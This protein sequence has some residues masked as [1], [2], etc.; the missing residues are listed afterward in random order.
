MS[1]CVWK[2][3]VLVVAVIG[4]LSWIP[5]TQAEN[6]PQWRGARADGVSI[7]KDIA[8]RWNKQ[9]SIRWRTPLPGQGGATPIVWYEKIFLTSAEGDDLVAMCLA[10]D[11]GKTLW[12]KKIA[13]GNQD[14]RAGE[15]NSASPSHV[16]DLSLIHI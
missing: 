5:S 8:I 2:I 10:T 13:S 11:T 16:T 12:K 7:E 4:S 9:R 1:M 14:A 15:G 3:S 6:W